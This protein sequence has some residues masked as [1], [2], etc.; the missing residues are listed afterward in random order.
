MKATLGLYGAAAPGVGRDVIGVA[1]FDNTNANSRG[2]HHLTGRQEDRLQQFR[3]APAPPTSGSFPLARTGT[4][5]A[6]AD[7]CGALAAGSLA[8]KVALIRRGA[9]SFYQK[10]INAQNGRRGR[11]HHLQQRGRVPQSD[12]RAAHRQ[13]P[14]RWSRSPPST[15]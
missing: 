2:V 1:S 10:S 11:R 7:G 3:T 12:G 5:T 4:A 14:S 13:S 15:A 6:T 8:G 9:C